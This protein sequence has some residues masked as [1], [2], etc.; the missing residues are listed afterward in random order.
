M[1]FHPKHV[2]STKSR[3]LH[4]NYFLRAGNILPVSL[5]VHN[6]RGLKEFDTAGNTTRRRVFENAI[7][8]SSS[9]LLNDTFSA[10][11]LN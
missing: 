8:V 3:D 11:R 7:M 4:K 2:Y 1:K 9:I 10:S 6:R 5:A